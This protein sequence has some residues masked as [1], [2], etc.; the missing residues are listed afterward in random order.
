M[1]IEAAPP[2]LSSPLLPHLTIARPRRRATRVAVVA[3]LLA[4][5][6]PRLEASTSQGKQP[7]TRAILPRE[8]AH[9]AV[10]ARDAWTGGL[11]AFVPAARFPVQPRGTCPPPPRLRGECE[12]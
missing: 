3:L 12:R 4:L 6:L 11:S 10:I 2:R 5:A 1:H 7:A 8:H 9:P